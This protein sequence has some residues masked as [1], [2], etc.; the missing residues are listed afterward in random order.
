MSSVYVGGRMR[1]ARRRPRFRAGPVRA[2]VAAGVRR[3]VAPV[4]VAGVVLVGMTAVGACSGDVSAGPCDRPERQ[5]AQLP[6]IHV[7]PGQPEPSYLSDPPTSGPH[8]PLTSVP[9]VFDTPVPR[10]TQ[11]GIL[12]RGMVLV[13]YRPDL[14]LDEQQRLVGLAAGPVTVAPNPQLDRPVVASAWLY[15]LRC[16]A[17]DTAALADFVTNRTADAPGGH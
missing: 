12:E 3:A 15:L 2:A 5:R 14:P 16:D 13:Q 8:A 10:P 17:V 9:P 6:A 4:L 1:T 7:L 11:V